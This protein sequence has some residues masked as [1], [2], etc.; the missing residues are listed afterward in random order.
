M[1][2]TNILK[3]YILVLNHMYLIFS[4]YIL[5][6]LWTRRL[7]VLT[8]CLVAILIIVLICVFFVQVVVLIKE[9]LVFWYVK[10][11]LTNVEF[12]IVNKSLIM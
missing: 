4:K 9:I 11:V 5:S 1:I 8:P 3:L 12:V 7:N 2:T 6:F 10:D